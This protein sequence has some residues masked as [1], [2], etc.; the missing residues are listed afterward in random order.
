ML[1]FSQRSL[2]YSASAA[3]VS[4]LFAAGFFAAGFFAAGFFVANAGADVSE[5]ANA[6]VTANA[7]PFR[8]E[9]FMLPPFGITL[10]TFANLL[11]LGSSEL[12]VNLSHRD[13]GGL[14]FK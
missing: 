3:V 12:G 8:V 2:R 10:P 11:S 14:V 7:R 1:S 5:S 6:A 9:F 13:Q 4:A